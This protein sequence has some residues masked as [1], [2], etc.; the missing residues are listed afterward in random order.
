MGKRGKRGKRNK[1]QQ[2]VDDQLTVKELINSRKK[3]KEKNK[4]PFENIKLPPPR[5]AQ[6]KP[7]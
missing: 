1:W 6:R 4:K 2:E 3:E 5:E 7:E